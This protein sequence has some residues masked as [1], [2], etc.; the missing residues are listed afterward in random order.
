[1]A[2]DRRARIVVGV[3]AL[4]GVVVEAGG[5]ESQFRA[6]V[7]HAVAAVGETLN[8]DLLIEFADAVGELIALEWLERWAA[9]LGDE[10]QP[11]QR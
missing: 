1:M 7:A 4:A 8:A 10:D 6:S 11:A 5:N 2:D 9:E 3:A